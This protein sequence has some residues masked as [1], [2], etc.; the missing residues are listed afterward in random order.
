MDK[1]DKIRPIPGLMWAAD[2]LTGQKPFA[3]NNKKGEGFKEILEKE[4]EKLKNKR[5]D[6]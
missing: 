1:K 6:E 2:I 3:T 5:N 4:I